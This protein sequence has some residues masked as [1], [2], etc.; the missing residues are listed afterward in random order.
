MSCG[1]RKKSRESPTTI[2]YKNPPFQLKTTVLPRRHPL[3]FLSSSSIRTVAT[4]SSQRSSSAQH[5]S[6]SSSLQISLGAAIYATA[7]DIVDLCDAHQ[8]MSAAR[9]LA[10]KGGA[11]GGGTSVEGVDRLAASAT[12][13]T[14]AVDI[15]RRLGQGK[16]GLGEILSDREGNGTAEEASAAKSAALGAVRDLADLLASEVRVLVCMLKERWWF[17]MSSTANTPKGRS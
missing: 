14:G 6:L 13:L 11:G 12:S 8:T 5:I 15:L 17:T 3:R 4:A 1:T 10:E 16:G 2:N 9:S 7:Q